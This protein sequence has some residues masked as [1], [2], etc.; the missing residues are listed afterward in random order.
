MV[1]YHKTASPLL[2]AEVLQSIVSATAQIT[3]FVAFM[4]TVWLA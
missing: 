3:H 2:L 4:R 1:S